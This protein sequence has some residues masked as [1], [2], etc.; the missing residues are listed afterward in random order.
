M[1]IIKPINK[2]VLERANKLRDEF[3]MLIQPNLSDYDMLVLLEE[4]ERLTVEV[5]DLKLLLEKERK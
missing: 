4:V 5:R 2:K 3:P 1:T